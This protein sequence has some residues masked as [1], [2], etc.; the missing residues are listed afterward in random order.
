[1]LYSIVQCARANGLEPYRYLRQLF[2][3]LPAIDQGDTEAIQALLLWTVAKQQAAVV[4]S[5]NLENAA[6]A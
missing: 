3:Q 4:D 6:A 5:K 1:M 2:E